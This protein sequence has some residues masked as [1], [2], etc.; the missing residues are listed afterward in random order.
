GAGVE[1]LYPLTPLQ[2]GM[3]FHSLVDTEGRAY[4]DQFRLRLDAGTDE[5]ALAAALQRVVDR[6]PILRSSVVWEEV[7]EPL[8]V[9]HRTVVL[10]V[11][12]QDWRHLT[13]AEQEERLAADLA[14]GIDLTRAPLL[15]A[16]IARLP[17][18]EVLLVW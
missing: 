16:L 7:D 13:E 2:A 4:L 15:R 1:D 18:D 17:G 6:T 9:V 8:Q 5:Q 14:A 12:H 10:P 11:A 3:L